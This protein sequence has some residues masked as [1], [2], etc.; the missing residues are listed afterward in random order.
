MKVKRIVFEEKESK[1]TDNQLWNRHDNQPDN[2][3]RGE[4]E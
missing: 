4:K 2:D 1:M 3:T